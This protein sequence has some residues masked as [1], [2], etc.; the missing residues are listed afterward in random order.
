MTATAQGSDPSG[1]DKGRKVKASLRLWSRRV[2]GDESSCCSA[3]RRTPL[4][5]SP[6]LSDLS[7]LQVEK[8]PQVVLANLGE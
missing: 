8:G 7:G 1:P 2:S 4:E 6:P 3:H 5:W